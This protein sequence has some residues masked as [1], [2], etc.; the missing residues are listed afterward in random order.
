VAPD[1]SGVSANSPTDGAASLPSAAVLLLC[2]LLLG[3]G[4]AAAILR[5]PAPAQE[6]RVVTYPPPASAPEATM[7]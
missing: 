6:V 4:Y 5:G 3:A 2:L 1:A 7:E